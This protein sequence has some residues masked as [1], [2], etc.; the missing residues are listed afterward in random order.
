MKIK[1]RHLSPV[2]LI[3]AKELLDKFDTDIADSTKDKDHVIA[4]F[5]ENIRVLVKTHL[6]IPLQR[7]IQRPPG[8]LLLR[9]AETLVGKKRFERDCMA[10]L[11]DWHEEYFEALDQERGRAKMTAIRIRHTYAFLRATG[12]LVGLETAGKLITKLLDKIGSA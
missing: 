11:A 6:S 10:A 5:E 2:G 7:R 8:S 4:E 9:V 3:I 12:W 1:D